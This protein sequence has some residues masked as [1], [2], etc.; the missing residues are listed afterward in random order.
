MKISLPKND[1]LLMTVNQ[2]NF[3]FKDKKLVNKKNIKKSFEI[4][5]ERTEYCFN[6]INDK[7][8]SKNKE[9]FFNHLHTDQYSIFLYFLSNTC[10]KENSDKSLSDKIYYLNKVLHSID[11]F[12]EVILPDIFLLVHPIGT[13][14]GRA[15]YS[16]FFVAYQKCTVG[17]SN[18]QHPAFGKFVTLRPGSFVL[19]KSII[20]DNSEISAGSILIDK[21]IKK[22]SLYI[23]NP[24]KNYI[25]SK[26]N[27]RNNFW[28][29]S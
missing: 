20:G 13:V 24:K 3:L 18:N 25:L 29:L 8:Y 6:K 11:I 2:L 27:K 21:S 9:I 22:N 15:K 26:K 4:A 5:L 1:F 14:L 17:V 16:N 10:F 23:G 12:Y 19:G 7:Y 28:K